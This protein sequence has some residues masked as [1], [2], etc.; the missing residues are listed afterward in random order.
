MTTPRDEE[1]RHA[2]EETRVD[3]P[4]T[5][6]PESAHHNPVAFPNVDRTVPDEGRAFAPPPFEPLGERAPMLPARPAGDGP[7]GADLG[8]P[9]GGRNSRWR[10]IA[11]GIATLLVVALIGGTL[12]FLGGRPATPS[13]VAQFAPANA[14]IYTELR[15]DLPGDQRDRLASFMSNFPGF[16]DQASFQQKIDET[17]ANA[18]RSTNTGLEWQRDISPWFGGEVGLFSATL[19]PSPGTPPSFTIVLSVKDRAKLDELVSARLTGSDMQPEDYKGQ[20]IWTGNASADA[21]RISFAVTDEALV[22]SARNEELKAALD[23]K[24]GEQPGLADDAFFTGQ[25]GQMHADRLALIYYDYSRLLE[26]MPPGASILPAECMGELQA[27]TNVR[28]LGE[29]RAESDHL[30]LNMRSQFPTGGNLPPAPQNKRTTLADS[31]PTSSI[32]YVEMRQVGANIKYLVDQLIT[33]M[34]TSGGSLFDL[35][36]L[37]QLIGTKPQDYFDFLDD[38]AFAVTLAD[39]KFGGGLIATVDDENVARTRVERLLSVV[40]LG[41]IGLGGGLTVEE[42]QHGDVAVTVIKLGAGLVPGGEA[43]SIAIAVSGGRVYLGVDDFVTSALDR[44]AA[45]SLSTTPRFQGALT[46]TGAETAGIV[47][48]D[49]GALRSFAES[50]MPS[51]ARGN[52]DTE[53]KPFLEPITHFVAI[54]RNENG[55]NASHA[56]LYVE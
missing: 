4:V 22:V 23:I 53:V 33:C 41:G 20:T 31:M 39:G 43:P 1:A 34:N 37:E 52:Y 15:L 45:D 27:A 3:I 48:I 56:F 49:I 30:A 47:Y 21:Q 29:V 14:A 54:S 25:L 5:R 12:M 10:W 11:A 9:V 17:L 38:A 46:E 50:Q 44:A 51:G 28:L 2:D 32:V 19:A 40:R 36:G 55:I 8:A 6:D 42:Q 7:A 26:S 24:A 18:L 35:N 16:A 13:L